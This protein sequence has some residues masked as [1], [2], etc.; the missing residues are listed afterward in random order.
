M[1]FTIDAACGCDIGKRRANNEDNF[2]FNGTYLMPD[3]LPPDQIAQMEA[4]VKTGLCLAV[5]DG[6]GG[7]ELGEVASHQAAKQ[8]SQRRKAP[9]FRPQRHLRQ[10]VSQLN[11]AVVAAQK[12]LLTAR[13]A[14]TLAM[15]WF[16]KRHVY[17]CNVGDSRI[18]RLQNGSLQQLSV[19]HV[20]IR[21]GQEHRKAP[22]TRYLGIDPAE[23]LLEPYIC[24]VPL[25]AGDTYLICSDGLT[26]MVTEP[27]ISQILHTG[28]DASACTR[29]LIDTALD[30]GGKDNVTVIVCKLR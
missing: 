13:M 3:T 21:P 1:A 10:L 25:V 9:L 27:E 29:L 23:M 2:F 18:Y 15:L 4:P 28:G 22:L 6:V 26:D 5:F 16:H 24:P 8:L 12:E 19:D 17:V 20:A 30:H 14:T 7:E 11:D